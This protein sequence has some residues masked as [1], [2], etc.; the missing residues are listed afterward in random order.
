MIRSF[1]FYFTYQSLMLPSLLITYPFTHAYHM[2][3]V[4]P[5]LWPKEASGAISIHRYRLLRLGVILVHQYGV[6]VIFASNTESYGIGSYHTSAYHHIIY[7][8]QW[9]MVIRTTT[10]TSHIWTT[11]VMVMVILVWTHRPLPL[12]YQH[13]QQAMAMGMDMM[14][15]SEAND[16]Q[17]CWLKPRWCSWMKWNNNYAWYA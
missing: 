17:H 7:H 13:Q 15:V 8:R 5:Q 1:D 3:C 14:D 11:M 16:V 12:P 9:I 10:M 4:S 6:R 2:I